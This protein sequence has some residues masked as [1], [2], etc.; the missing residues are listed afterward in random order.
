M[1]THWINSNGGPYILA[2]NRV[3]SLWRAT[4]G[5]SVDHGDGCANDYQR[6]CEINGYAGVIQSN[7]ESM[8]VIGDLPSDLAVY[9]N[10]DTEVVL[11]KWVGAES[12]EQILA[13]L[14]VERELPFQRLNF[15]LKITESPLVIFDSSELFADA[16]ENKLSL[17]LSLGTY[18]VE[19]LSYEPHDQLMLQLFRL[20]KLLSNTTP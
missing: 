13:A 20:R 19:V 5:I 8:L 11:V 6:A 4:N 15:D 9:L 18:S 7:G 16:G 1:R 17:K 14:D 2:S 12:E 3:A 10:T